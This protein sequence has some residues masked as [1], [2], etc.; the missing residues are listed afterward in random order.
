MRA[1]VLTARSRAALV[2]DEALD[3]DEEVSSTKAPLTG[4]TLGHS[5]KLAAQL[6]VREVFRLQ[7]RSVQLGIHSVPKPR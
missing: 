2:D 6:G 4:L 5:S 1:P 3:E 7:L